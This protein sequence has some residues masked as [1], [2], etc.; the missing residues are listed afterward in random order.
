[1]TRRQQIFTFGPSQVWVPVQGFFF[2]ALSLS[3]LGVEERCDG[4]I[5]TR[6]GC[7]STSSG[8]AV[9]IEKLRIFRLFL[10][11]GLRTRGGVVSRAK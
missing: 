3:P 7:D 1:M 8:L 4:Q 11:G 10:W 6:H 5:E 2:R 9:G